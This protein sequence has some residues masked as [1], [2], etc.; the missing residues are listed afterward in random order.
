MR[1]NDKQEINHVAST[2]QVQ[3]RLQLNSL[4]LSSSINCNCSF[5]LQSLKWE[6][7]VATR[8]AR[9]FFTSGDA[10]AEE[11]YQDTEVQ[12]PLLTIE[13]EASYDDIA[14]SIQSETL[15]AASITSLV[16]LV[17]AIASICFSATN[18][19]KQFGYAAYP[20]PVLPF[21][22][23]TIANLCANAFA[24][25]YSL[26]YL[27]RS[28]EVSEARKRCTRGWDPKLRSCRKTQT[29]SQFELILES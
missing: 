3:R 28:L 23:M 8:L 6:L 11:T 25:N 16:Q 10:D 17:F 20:F 4:S 22:A 19:T 27:I 18:A 7:P 2:A 21:V 13:N 26:L 1:W 14:V 12:S 29:K 15:F 9:D 24:E 5:C